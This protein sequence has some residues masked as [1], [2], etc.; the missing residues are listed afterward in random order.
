MLRLVFAAALLGV[1]TL[2]VGAAESAQKKPPP[3]ILY[4]LLS[5]SPQN[6]VGIFLGERLKDYDPQTMRVINYDF[7]LHLIFVFVEAKAGAPKEVAYATLEQTVACPETISATDFVA[8]TADGKVVSRAA[9]VPGYV[10]ERMTPAWTKILKG[11]L[12]AGAKQALAPAPMPAP[13]APANQPPGAPPAPGAKRLTALDPDHRQTPHVKSPA[14]AL[15]QARAA[16]AEMVAAA[17][18]PE[19]GEFVVGDPLKDQGIPILDMAS[20]TK[21]G[22]KKR[23][24]W[25][26]VARPTWA[27]NNYDPK[28]YMRASYDIDCDAQT[29]RPVR[30]AF[31]DFD[32]SVLVAIG[33]GRDD[34]RFGLPP[35][36]GN[37]HAL[38][39]FLVEACQSDG[40]GTFQKTYRKFSEALAAAQAKAGI[41]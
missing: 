3:G 25:A 36:Y 14:E 11:Q 41:R 6:G 13:L 31:F 33:P 7:T 19:A 8:F 16:H 2:S 27:P 39:A 40:P 35:S 9:S 10:A 28:S 24:S 29:A 20:L 18:W 12:C 4:H 22:G 34:E 26:L 23:I 32:R 1:L 30:T 5:S 21:P 37:P 38:D 15:A 17:N